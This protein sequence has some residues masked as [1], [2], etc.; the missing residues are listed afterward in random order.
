MIIFEPTIFP[1]LI[2]TVLIKGFPLNFSLEID[3]N[4]TLSPMPKWK[5]WVGVTDDKEGTW[6]VASA[7]SHN[8][9]V[10]ADM[11]KHQ[12]TKGDGKGQEAPL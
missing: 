9:K 8:F 7:S 6:Y 2:V 4:L 5:I 10:W 11:H 3:W 1:M 12:K